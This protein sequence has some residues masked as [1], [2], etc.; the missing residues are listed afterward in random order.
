MVSG[1]RSSVPRSRRERLATVWSITATVLALIGLVDLTHQL[2]EWAAFIHEIA[3]KYAEVRGWCFNRLPFRIP[4]EWHN[5]VVLGFILLSVANVGYY[6]RT[7][8]VLLYQLVRAFGN[9]KLKAVLEELEGRN[10]PMA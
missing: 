3:E 8:Y 7:G 5:Y 6:R 10:L 4:Q 2:V 1:E 9:R